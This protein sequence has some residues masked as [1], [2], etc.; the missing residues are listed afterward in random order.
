MRIKQLGMNR[1]APRLD[2]I[3]PV[4]RHVTRLG[5]KALRTVASR[6]T[7][8]PEQHYLTTSTPQLGRRVHFTG[9]VALTVVEEG[10][11]MPL[12]HDH[13]P[14]RCELYRTSLR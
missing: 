4:D 9:G 14:A 2:A 1:D 11:E 12:I 10:T 5:G 13:D 7:S 6:T 3:K 8:V